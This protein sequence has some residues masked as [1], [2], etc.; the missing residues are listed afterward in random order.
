MIKIILSGHKMA[1]KVFNIISIYFADINSESTSCDSPLL[2]GF[3]SDVTSENG[4]TYA[5][6]E[7]SASNPLSA[8]GDL[9][10]PLL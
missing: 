7:V 1:Y 8:N 9:L 5:T 6:Y 3:S 10:H 2:A 4:E